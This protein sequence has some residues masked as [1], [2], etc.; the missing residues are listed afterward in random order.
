V[1]ER[2]FGDWQSQVE[3]GS[4][5][6]DVGCAD[7]LSTFPLARPGVEVLAFDISRESLVLATAEAAERGLDNVTFFVADAD[8]FPLRDEIVDEVTCFG[9]LHHVPD[10]ARTVGEIGRVLKPGGVYLGS[11]NNRTPLRPVFDLLM[12]LRPLWKEE[13]GAEALIGRADLQRWSADTPLELE[14][15]PNVF[16]PPHLCNVLGLSGARRLLRWTDAVLGRIPGI[17]RWGGLI[18]IRGRKRDS[19]EPAG[20]VLGSQGEPTQPALNPLD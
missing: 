7:G 20:H 10:P 2:T 16:V 8:A 19:A 17:R 14:T 11:E 13:A 18:S 3:A 15:R 5:V 9:S 6:L 4:I 12:R 1:R